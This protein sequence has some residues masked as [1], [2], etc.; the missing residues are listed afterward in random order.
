MSIREEEDQVRRTANFISFSLRCALTGERLVATSS[1]L[2]LHVLIAFG[3]THSIF[4]ISDRFLKQLIVLS[5]A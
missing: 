5:Y 2:P 1:I 3:A 4:A